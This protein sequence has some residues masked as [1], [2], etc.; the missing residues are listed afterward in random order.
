MYFSKHTTAPSPPS[1]DYEII[2]GLV[3]FQKEQARLHINW[4]GCGKWRRRGGGERR[5]R[6]IRKTKGSMKGVGGGGREVP[7][8][9]LGSGRVGRQWQ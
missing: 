2:P 6:T 4:G 3:Y 9:H 7:S 1:P 5:E 8:N